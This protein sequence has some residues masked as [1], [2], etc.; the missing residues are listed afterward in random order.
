MRRYFV[1]TEDGVGADSLEAAL[2]TEKTRL[3]ADYDALLQSL[4]PKSTKFDSKEDESKFVKDKKATEAEHRQKVQLGLR[5][6]VFERVEVDFYKFKDR[7][8]EGKAWM[9]PRDPVL[10]DTMFWM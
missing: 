2:K 6:F 10:K 7:L 9:N 5:R 8:E 1:M 3:V 4:Y